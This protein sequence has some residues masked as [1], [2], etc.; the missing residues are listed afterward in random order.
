[1]RNLFLDRNLLV[2]TMAPDGAAFFSG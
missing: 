1:M 2:Q